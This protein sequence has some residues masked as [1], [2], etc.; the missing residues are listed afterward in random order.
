MPMRGE[1]KETAVSELRSVALYDCAS[2]ILS[3]AR[4]NPMIHFRSA[5]VGAVVQLSR[6]GDLILCAPGFGTRM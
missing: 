4:A 3:A 1:S 5:A 6:L 2:A